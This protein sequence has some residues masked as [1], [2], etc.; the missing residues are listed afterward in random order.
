MYEWTSSSTPR[1]SKSTYD[2]QHFQNLKSNL[3]VEENCKI[4][5]VKFPLTCYE[6]FKE[7]KGKSE[8]SGN[9]EQGITDKSSQADCNWGN[10]EHHIN[11][12][13]R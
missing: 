12:V 3:D 4:I 2:N 9:D 10:G 8:G 11:K 1:S 7:P 13:Y 6:L 5:S